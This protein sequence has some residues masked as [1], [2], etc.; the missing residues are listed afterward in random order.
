MSMSFVPQGDGTTV[1]KTDF[2]YYR[3]TK[4]KYYQHYDGAEAALDAAHAHLQFVQNR[5]GA[6]LISH[7]VDHDMN[8][9]AVFLTYVEC[10][11]VR[12]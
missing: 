11:E 9:Q 5:L 7:I 10:H 8:R 1:V 12:I 4:R 6:R 3:G 2:Q